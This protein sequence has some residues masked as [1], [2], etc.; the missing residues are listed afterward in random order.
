M[1]NSIFLNLKNT[2]YYS[3]VLII[4]L[5]VTA[6][7]DV[8]SQTTLLT[9]ASGNGWSAYSLPTPGGIPP[10]CSGGP[11]FPYSVFTGQPSGWANCGF[12]SN[13]TVQ[14]FPFYGSVGMWVDETAGEVYGALFQSSFNVT[15]V[16]HP[17]WIDFVADNDIQIY[18][19]GNLMP[20]GPFNWTSAPYSECI[21]ASF[22]NQ[23][24]NCIAFQVTEWC[25]AATR[26]LL[27][28]LTDSSKAEITP[29]NPEVCEDGPSITFS[30]TP[31]GGTWSGSGISSVGVFNTNNKSPGVYP[32]YYSS[33][34]S[35]APCP[36]FD[37]AYVTVNP[38]PVILASAVKGVI[39]AGES[40]SLIASGA[41]NYV[42]SNNVIGRVNQV[43]PSS[44][45]SY[46]VIG[47]DANGCTATSIVSVVVNPEP[48]I[49]TTPNNITFCPGDSIL[50][51]ASG[52]MNY[53]W[54]P[55]IN[56]NNSTSNPV[57][58]NP[59]SSQQYTVTGTDGNGCA[60]SALVDLTADEPVSLNIEK[61]GDISCL[62]PIVKLTASG[63][64]NY[65]WQP[66][67]YLNDPTSPNPTVTGLISNTKFIVTGTNAVCKAV[68]EIEVFI[69]NFNSGDHINMPNAFT[70]NGDGKNDCYRIVSNENYENFVFKI[71]N[72]WGQN[73]YNSTNT[74]E[75]W[76]G[77]FNGVEQPSGA[78]YYYLRAI[79]LCKKNFSLQGDIILI[80]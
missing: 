56:I 42:W 49:L 13:T 32:I 55:N 71:F 6:I 11:F 39:C 46:T 21:P 5:M 72:R 51:T 54:S 80:R 48:T 43:T 19:N 27:S 25:N 20:G 14:H 24:S 36:L 61:S 63:A 9:S 67:Q 29:V 53:S 35:T 26:V 58:V 69:G 75:C 38:M 18:I 57:I 73:V 4:V 47:T 68:A 22:L 66:A 50:I 79:D 44:T 78:Y 15:D 3:A 16:D 28:V 23:G 1:R 60:A 8:K 65:S 70:P 37:T 59:M 77:T 7:S 34:S 12:T 40:D 10:N 31:S 2:A 52:A 33:S 41:V 76:D 45:S 74:D 62:L 30:A 17:H 64:R